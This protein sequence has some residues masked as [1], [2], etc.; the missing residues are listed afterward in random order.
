MLRYALA[1][2]GG[3]LVFFLLVRG[4]IFYAASLPV[5]ARRSIIPRTGE[6]MRHDAP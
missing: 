5:G 2:V 1:V 4:W 6:P 3:Y